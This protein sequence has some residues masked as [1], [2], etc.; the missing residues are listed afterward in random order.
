MIS[1]VDPRLK[2][3]I[4]WMVRQFVYMHALLNLMDSGGEF[5]VKIPIDD[6]LCYTE[7]LCEGFMT[8]Y[9]LEVFLN[10][11]GS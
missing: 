4:Q 10:S 1:D 9:Y 6:L 5:C 8:T 3:S 7:S 11:D 2:N